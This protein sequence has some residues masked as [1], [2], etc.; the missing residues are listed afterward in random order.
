MGQ[1][2]FFVTHGGVILRAVDLGNA[3]SKIPGVLVHYP[4]SFAGLLCL[5]LGLPKGVEP[6]NAFLPFGF[7]LLAIGMMRRNFAHVGFWRNASDNHKLH[8][9]FKAFMSGIFWAAASWA[10]LRWWAL[11]VHLNEP[12][13]RWV[14]RY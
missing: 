14:L 7:G 11:D 2:L 4:E 9:T 3:F 1:N 6:A 10:F 5:V 8:F 12:W 13:T